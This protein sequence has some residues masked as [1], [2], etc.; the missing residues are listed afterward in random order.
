MTTKKKDEAKPEVE[1][2]KM[3]TYD[4]FIILAGRP[5]RGAKKDRCNDPAVRDGYCDKHHYDNW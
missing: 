4:D 3:I 5:P 2:C 1:R